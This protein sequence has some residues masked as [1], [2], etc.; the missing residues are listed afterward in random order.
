MENKKYE[1]KRIIMESLIRGGYLKK[2]SYE[3][4]LDEIINDS[5]NNLDLLL[6]KK[7]ENKD[8]EEYEEW[9]IDDINE[10][11]DEEIVEYEKCLPEYISSLPGSLR[12]TDPR[13]L[14]DRLDTIDKRLD[15]LDDEIDDEVEFQETAQN[16]IEEATKKKEEA[17]KNLDDYEKREQD[18][19]DT[20]EKLQ[21]E[22]IDGASELRDKWDGFSQEW[23][24]PE[25]LDALV[26]TIDGYFEHKGFLYSDE[27]EGLHNIA[28]MLDGYANDM[29]DGGDEDITYYPVYRMAQDIRDFAD[30]YDINKHPMGDE[31]SDLSSIAGQGK[32]TEWRETIE[33]SDEIIER[34]H[35]L[36]NDSVKTQ[37]KKEKERK[38]L[39][40]NKGKTEQRLSQAERN[41]YN[42]P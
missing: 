12:S 4:K 41:L 14:Q 20:D 10:L 13:E 38:D 18:F 30:A 25:S 27:V 31:L 7:Q 11:S 9:D 22:A 39:K 3:D 35:E 24:V 2:P 36:I 6:K 1:Y 37:A 28:D 23:D 19:L 16:E 34:N 42:I 21:G 17:Q 29:T 33:E 40:D 5:F 8:L 32:P 26:R 15:E